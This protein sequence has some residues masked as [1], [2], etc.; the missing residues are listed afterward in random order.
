M[1]YHRLVIS[2]NSHLALP[3]SLPKNLIWLS[4]LAQLHFS[5]IKLVS[6]RM[7]SA[8]P[9][10]MMSRHVTCG[11][12][13]G[14]EPVLRELGVYE[15]VRFARISVMLPVQAIS[16]PERVLCL[17]GLSPGPKRRLLPRKGALLKQE[18]HAKKGVK[19]IT[20]V[21]LCI[22]S[23]VPSNTQMRFPPENTCPLLIHVSTEF[24]RD[25]WHKNRSGPLRLLLNIG[26]HTFR[27]ESSLPEEPP[28]PDLARAVEALL[29][30]WRLEI[31]SILAVNGTKY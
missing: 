6:P 27:Q 16:R 17:S 21:S 24:H 13:F 22:S 5:W 4:C 29:L 20:L 15:S 25:S 10:T 23:A 12:P 2:E 1:K 8:G 19:K 26:P 14:S 31:R 9:S 3:H 30:D 18:R 11:G 7:L 28:V